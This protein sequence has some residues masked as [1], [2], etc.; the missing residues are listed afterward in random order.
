MIE[1]ELIALWQSSP[2][3]ERIKFEKSKLMLDVQSKLDSFDRAV[4]RRDFLEIGTAIVIIPLFAYQVYN[5]PNYLA[6]FGA[7]WIV[8]YV[9][10]VIYR[11]L[12]AKK[13]KPKEVSSYL[14]YLKQ[15]KKYLERQKKLLDSVL[16]WYVLPCLMGCAI[17]MTGMLDL[18][19]KS[20]YEIIRMRKVWIAVSSFTIIGVFVPR[21]NKWAVKK[22]LLPRIK[23]V[24]EL[25]RLMEEEK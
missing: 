20:W 4:N 7:T 23:K 2:K 3:H 24:N 16:Y 6:K 9:V 19:N 13:N 18:L 21:L 10:Y 17:M 1:N 12:D 22:E 25:I 11:L 8:V 15:C 5:Q 14:E